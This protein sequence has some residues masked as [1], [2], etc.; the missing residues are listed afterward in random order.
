MQEVFVKICGI[1]N[2]DDALYCADCGAD[3]LGFNFHTR[4]VRYIRPEETH[5]IVERLPEHVTKVGVFVNSRRARIEKITREVKLSALQLHGNEHPEDC[6]NFDV[7]VIK[8][9][10]V[11]PSFDPS[12]LLRYQVDAYLL[13]TQIQGSYGGTG[14]SFD[15]NV[16]VGSK[17]YGKIIISGGLDPSNIEAAVKFVRPYGVDVC[18]GIE[19]KPGKK[20]RKMVRDFIAKAKS[21]V[22]G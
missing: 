10:R 7:S 5:K 13:D 6:L 20:D 18:S 9:M 15:W 3:A 2:L 8:A 4:S 16:A 12:D 21:L 19:S 11:G 22:Y 14:Q 17:P 1:T